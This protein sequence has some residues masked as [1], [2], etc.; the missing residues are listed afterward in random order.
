M[1]HTFFCQFLLQR[2][3]KSIYFDHTLDNFQAMGQ[4]PSW[5]CIH[6]TFFVCLIDTRL[7]FHKWDYFVKSYLVYVNS[8]TTLKSFWLHRRPNDFTK[9]QKCLITFFVC[10]RAHFNYNNPEKSEM[11]FNKSDVFHVVDTLHNGVVGSW[12]AFRMGKWNH[13]SSFSSYEEIYRES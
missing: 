8:K 7:P 10:F 12:Q 3:M 2:K 13:Q 1:V 11:S 5:S 4:K 9:E 6:D